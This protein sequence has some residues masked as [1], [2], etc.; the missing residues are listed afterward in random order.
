MMMSG[1]DRKEFGKALISGAAAVAAPSIASAAAGEGARFSIFGGAASEPYTLGEKLYSPYSPFGTGEDRV[2]SKYN[3]AEVNFNVGIV[4]ESLNR[5]EKTRGYLEK[6][7][8]MDT[9]DE[10]TRYMYNTRK[11][12][13]Y[14]SAKVNDPEVESKKKA[15]YKDIE[16]I[17]VS[18]KRKDQATALA[19]QASAVVNLSEFLE[20]F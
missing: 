16:T 14:L 9:V 11:S 2:Y 13:N 3:D 10:L 7:V 8:W 12:M 4:K 6:K 19:A 5:L 17:T 18:C 20:Y 1:M 15:F